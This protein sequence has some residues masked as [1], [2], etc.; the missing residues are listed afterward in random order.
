[1]A[2]KKN[3]KTV[4]CDAISQIDEIHSG[5]FETIWQETPC[6]MLCTQELGQHFTKARHIIFTIL[7]IDVGEI[8]MS[9]T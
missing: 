8:T 7:D 2:N 4:T 5:P 3:A 6:Y 9:Y 1:M